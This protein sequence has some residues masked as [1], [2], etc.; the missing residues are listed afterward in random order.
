MIDIK[1]A[2]TAA[3]VLIAL[4]LPGAAQTSGPDAG[5]TPSTPPPATGP[6]GTAVSPALVTKTGAALRQVSDIRQSYAPRVASAK[7]DDEKQSLQQQAMDEAVRAI[8]AQ[9]LSVDQYNQVIRLAQADPTLQDQ[10]VTAAK[11]SK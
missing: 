9:G 4:T 5:A 10:L 8:N 1:A 6:S 3:T 11:A 2:A 7:S